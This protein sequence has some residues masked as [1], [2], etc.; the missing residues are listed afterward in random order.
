MSS[1]G[2]G[3]RP[4]SGSGGGG[5]KSRSGG[6]SMRQTQTDRDRVGSAKPVAVASHGVA[7]S[8]AT[9]TASRPLPQQQTV[10]QISGD[11]ENVQQQQQM[12]RQQHMQQQQQQ[13]QQRQQQQQPP[14]P[15]PPQVVTAVPSNVGGP[16]MLSTTTP[17]QAIS[18]ES[19]LPP[20]VQRSLGDRSYDKRKNAALEIESLVKSL[21]ESGNT[22]MIHSVLTVLSNDFCTSM[23][24]NYRKGGLIGIAATAIGLMGNTRLYLDAM[25]PPV[26]QC[27]DDPESR[28]RY[29]ACESLYNIA[30]VARTAILRYFND[31]FDGLT[32][33]FADVDVDV[34]NGASLLDRLVKDIVT[35]SDSFQ[36]EQFLPLLQTYIR[37]T[38]PYIRQLLVSWI[39]VLDSVPDISMIDYLPD[40]LDGLFN[41]LSDSN[42]EI[43]QAAD[44][45]L[46]EF[47]REV[48]TS[49]VV[50]F[51]PMVSILVSQCHSR[52]PLNRLTAMTW[53]TELIHHPH[54]GGD[55][56]LPY[57]SEVLA[58]IMSC[59]SDTEAE[60]RT[61]SER[62]NADLLTLVRD[63]SGSFELRPL[64][65]T[66][67]KELLGKDDVPTKMAA[68]R[69]INMLLE[70]RKDDMR[71]F[72]PDLLPVLLRT[73]S[74]PSDPVVILTL[75]VLSRI[76]LADQKGKGKGLLLG[77]PSKMHKSTRT[78]EKARELRARQKGLRTPTSSAAV[79]I[80]G[81]PPPDDQFQMVLDAILGLF[82][83]DRRLL[84]T[85]GSLVVR[86][87]CVLLSAE[88]VYIRL[89]GAL[90]SVDFSLA[91][92]GESES[93]VG[94]TAGQ[95]RDEN[96]SLEF[97][98]TMVQTLNLILLT[99]AELHGL[100]SLL[101]KS[102]AKKGTGVVSSLRY[103]ENEETKAAD[104]D[105]AV[106]ARVFSALFHC[107]CHNPV[108]TFS[109]CL[110]AQAYDVAFA[111]VKKFSE[112]EVTV[113]FLMQVDKLVHLLES[114]VFI[115]LRLQLLDVE[116]PQH[117]Y[118]LKSCYGLLMLV[119]QSDAFRSLNDR[120]ATVCNLRDNLGASQTIK[121][122]EPIS[123]VSSQL[124][125]S[126]KRLLERFDEVMEL[127]RIEREKAR[128]KAE[129]EVEP[130]GNGV[131]SSSDGMALPLSPSGASVT[132]STPFGSKG[133]IYVSG[134]LPGSKGLVP[135]QLDPPPPP[136]PSTR[137]GFLPQTGPRSL[138]P[139]PSS[140]VATKGGRGLDPSM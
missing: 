85:R 77:S 20:I 87:L 92:D 15:P 93:I 14:P 89:A 135:P 28:V 74:D 123:L 49:T 10:Q 104:D 48:R 78:L 105:T 134:S 18:V 22:A 122:S 137:P 106:G 29:Y 17:A 99:A 24:A 45:A 88:S 133:D 98:G 131:G 109:L 12:Q 57:H 124:G 1:R 8:R 102:F 110:L 81:V 21:Q 16:P 96:Y 127:H 140:S 27:F 4:Y 37:R 112:L 86:K 71:I 82:A 126:T 59:L 19:P 64:L 114:P 35:E 139:R 5:P 107:W 51:G 63:T 90:S 13:M 44:S 118:L 38:N 6:G 46:S 69:W 36:V 129:M 65:D 42:R 58:A 80:P 132:P 83:S 136:S 73:L 31:I 130:A 60:I 3:D 68:L 2:R 100:R 50:E 66:L 25:L 62:A 67:T 84:E 30:K 91:G 119:P 23:N 7:V 39:T 32:K 41:M 26:L 70:K 128:E 52:D 117:P 111:L 11:Y 108:A 125:P 103:S 53:L 95:G 75:Q 54:S 94:S 76:S 9:G 34:K 56:L 79:D 55:A 101:A 72:I 97:V 121:T 47:L 115:H 138:G 43:R 116:K 120:L 61:V 113:G 33:L 40:F